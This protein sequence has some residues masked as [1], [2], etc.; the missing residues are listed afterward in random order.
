MFTL[1]IPDTP[2]SQFP[3]SNNDA[4]IQG[5]SG[6]LLGNLPQPSFKTPV[7]NPLNRELPSSQC[8]IFT[9]V[10][11]QVI[12]ETI[13]VSNN[14]GHSHS[15]HDIDIDVSVYLSNISNVNDTST[16]TTTLAPSSAHRQPPYFPTCPRPL[17]RC[18]GPASMRQTTMLIPSAF[19]L[20]VRLQR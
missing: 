3:L 2:A 8:P 16:F 6:H 20:A 10:H 18:P 12:I 7:A 15:E 5:I 13:L 1:L 17:S 14:K 11:I 19:C 4:G 9:F